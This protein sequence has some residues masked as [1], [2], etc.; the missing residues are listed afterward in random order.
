M[1][2][3]NL[4]RSRKISLENQYNLQ[5]HLQDISLRDLDYLNRCLI[6]Y[7]KDEIDTRI[8]HV[9]LT[10]EGKKLFDEIFTIQKKR[11]YKAFLSSDSDEVISFDK[12]LKKIIKMRL[13]N[14]G[15][16]SR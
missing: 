1:K 11:I 10:D 5:E 8:K 16:Y 4:A 12:V 14:N 3:I 9:F 2:I 13:Q 6:K 7:K 15:N